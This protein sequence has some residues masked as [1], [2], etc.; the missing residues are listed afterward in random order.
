MYNGIL[1]FGFKNFSVS[2]ATW[3]HVSTYHFHYCWCM[4]NSLLF[5]DGI[6]ANGQITIYV[7]DDK[8]M[9]IHFTQF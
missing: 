5:N 3:L 4:L 9:I 8:V 2:L 7:V 6:T 1:R